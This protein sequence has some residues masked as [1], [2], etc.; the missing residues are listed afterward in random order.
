M[1]GRPVVH[2]LLEMGAQVVSADISRSV[3]AARH[4]FAARGVDRLD[5]IPTDLARPPLQRESFD[6][7]F[8][9]GVLHH[10]RITASRWRPSPG[11]LRRRPNLR[12]ALRAHAWHCARLR[13]AVRRVKV[14]LPRLCSG[15]CCVSGPCSRSVASTCGASLVEPASDGETYREK[16]LTLLDHYALA[17]A[18]S[19]RPRSWTAGTR[20]RVQ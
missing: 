16:L 1:R 18:G 6:L 8:S 3:D 7:V 12:V 4:H 15:A 19:T 10:N 13:G 11:W 9:G 14:D 2:L 17:T 20:A 5:F